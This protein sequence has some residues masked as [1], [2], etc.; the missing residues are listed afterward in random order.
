MSVV[1][2]RLTRAAEE[3]I[4]GILR[5]TAI[6]FGPHQRDRYAELL[7]EAAGSVARNPF[8]PGSLARDSL[9]PGV[10]SFHISLSAS[11]RGAA[12]HILFYAV[13]PETGGTS[14]IVILRVLHER[15]DPERHLI[16]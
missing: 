4:G 10:R 1:G 15:M 5:A 7:E 14:R 16:D 8:R 9:A 6:Q 3:D 12:S 2:Y 11:R 13:E